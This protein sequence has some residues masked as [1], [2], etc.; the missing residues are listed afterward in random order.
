MALAIT[1]N[2][3]NPLVTRYPRPPEGCPS[4]KVL[5][6]ITF[7]Y[8]CSR[9]SGDR[10]F[11]ITDANFGFK[12]T[13]HDKKLVPG[14][15]VKY[16]PKKQKKQTHPNYGQ[17]ARITLQTSL[18]RNR[19]ALSQNR[20]MIPGSETV[21][22]D[23]KFINPLM[24]NNK[25]VNNKTEVPKSD[26]TLVPELEVYRC[27]DSFVPI[28]L[29]N[30]Y[31]QARDAFRNDPTGTV[32]PAFA[33]LY[34]TR[35]LW[36]QAMENG[37][38]NNHFILDDNNQPL[39]PKWWGV[40]TPFFVAQ[41]NLRQKLNTFIDSLV[42]IGFIPG[43][44]DQQSRIEGRKNNWRLKFI[45]PKGASPGQTI[46][47]PVNQQQIVVKIPLTL[48][49]PPTTIPQEGQSLT[50]PIL[51]SNNNSI[52]DNIKKTKKKNLPDIVFIP[53]LIEGQFANGKQLDVDKMVKPSKDQQ[54]TITNAEIIKHRDPVHTND[55]NFSV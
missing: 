32:P 36:L 15:L 11:D 46:T 21:M 12:T 55:D 18:P 43:K 8:K 25:L 13:G 10:V 44:I 6:R 29:I 28:T 26:L 23:I 52:Y 37:L 40:G 34:A 45:M 27:E 51:R 39:Y 5:Y 14:A 7:K 42:K 1:I 48:P 47:V 17:L 38:W 33:G 49:G 24:V 30:N 9:Y 2:S 31:I 53:T 16:T 22:Y 19:A 50:I 54:F 35:Q 4:G 20:P 3:P 41:Q